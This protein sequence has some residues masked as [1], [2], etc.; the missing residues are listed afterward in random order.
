MAGEH[1]CRRIGNLYESVLAHLEHAD[2]VGRAEAVLRRAQA[3][4]RPCRLALEVQHTVHH[5]L[6]DF[7]AGKRTLLVDVTDDEDGD[8]LVLR[9]LHQ[10]HRALFYLGRAAGR[11][12]EVAL[13]DRLNGVHDENIRRHQ[14]GFVD[15]LVNI[16][17]GE[18]IQL[19]RGNMQPRGAELDLPE[20]LLARYIEHAGVLAHLLAH[21]EQER[22]LAD[23]RLAA[24]EHKR[25]V[26]R[27]AAEHAVELAD[28]REKPLLV[29]G[30]DVLQEGRACGSTHE[31]R[32]AAR[33]RGGGRL[34]LAHGVPRAAGRTLSEPF[35]RLIAAVAA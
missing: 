20:R 17:F 5:M 12:A 35:R 15:D 10:A 28:A 19:G 14:L 26:H 18:D 29:A 34:E 24:D 8:V 4:E 11:G 27:A 9:V 31:A 33:Y 7:R 32:R 30:F 6:K 16:G 1:G 25:A 23:A 22:G 3:T 2:L 21:L 13:V